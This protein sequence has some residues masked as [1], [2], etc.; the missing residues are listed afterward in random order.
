MILILTFLSIS[1]LGCST[2]I[3]TKT[4]KTIIYTTLGKHDVAL[5]GIPRVASSKPIP[6]TVNDVL[7]TFNAGGYYLVHESDLTSLRKTI[8]KENEP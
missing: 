5:D 8:R 1:F 2:T 6:V 4:E 3:G 7:T